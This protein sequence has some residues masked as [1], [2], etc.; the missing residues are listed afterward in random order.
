[1]S[2]PHREAKVSAS[3]GRATE[4]LPCHECSLKDAK[5]ADLQRQVAKLR[6]KLGED[7]ELSDSDD[8]DEGTTCGIKIEEEGGDELDEDLKVEKLSLNSYTPAF[9]DC[10]LGMTRAHSHAVS[11]I[12]PGHC[13]AAASAVA[14]AATPCHI[15]AIP[16]E[17][18]FAVFEYIQ[19]RDGPVIRIPYQVPNRNRG[20]ICNRRRKQKNNVSYEQVLAEVCKTFRTLAFRLRGSSCLDV[21]TYH[22]SLRGRDDSDGTDEIGDGLDIVLGDPLRIQSV[23]T[24]HFDLNYMWTCFTKLS[25]VKT[26]TVVDLTRLQHFSIEDNGS[27]PGAVDGTLVDLVADA[28]IRAATTVAVEKSSPNSEE[29]RHLLKLQT[30]KL[31]GHDIFL[32][33]DLLLFL[34]WLQHSQLR[35]LVLEFRN[36]KESNNDAY[37]DLCNRKAIGDQTCFKVLRSVTIPW[38]F[39]IEDFSASMPVLESIHICCLEYPNKERQYIS[40]DPPLSLETLT[41]PTLRSFR[42]DGDG[43]DNALGLVPSFILNRLTS[44]HIRPKEEYPSTPEFSIDCFAKTLPKL[45]NLK[46]FSFDSYRLNLSADNVGEILDLIPSG[47]LETL[48]IHLDRRALSA[49][50]DELLEAL[51]LLL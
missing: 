34:R 16:D 38:P 20:S 18:L 6:E 37:G 48:R 39:I 49:D 14:P 42:W 47:K 22:P 17:L 19:P 41:Q 43:W 26:L 50:Y 33:Y 29:N 35:Q 25:M 24:L 36:S 10:L 23:R 40:K 8:G 51:R 1:M 45:H 2:V 5:I 7:P 4:A 3:L 27:L 28:F 11:S 13:V 30:F 44:V 21:C 46:S 31:V 15:L 12:N 32:S 9:A